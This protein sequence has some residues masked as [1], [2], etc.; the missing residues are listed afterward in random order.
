MSSLTS[1]STLNFPNREGVCERSV[2]SA[3]SASLRPCEPQPARP[4]VREVSQARVLGWVAMP[5]SRGS[6]R[7]R[8]RASISCIFCAVIAF[9]A[10]EPPGKPQTVA[11][12]LSDKSHG[13][14]KLCDWPLRESPAGTLTP[15]FSSWPTAGCGAADTDANTEVTFSPTPLKSQGEQVSNYT[16]SWF[17]HEQRVCFF[18]KQI[19]FV[20][21][22]TRAIVLL[23]AICNSTCKSFKVWVKDYT[24][25][26]HTKPRRRRLKVE[27]LRTLCLGWCK[28]GHLL[29]TEEDSRQYMCQSDG[30]AYFLLL[31][32]FNWRIVAL[33][34]SG[35]FCHTM[36]G[37][38]GKC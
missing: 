17:W 12:A 30:N 35:G 9:F 21:Q 1:F 23:K 22:T 2:S 28:T 34:C 18:L 15:T 10:T 24:L 4:P 25:L 8:D 20:L 7:R 38:S 31:F 37:I 29:Q 33:W 36:M 6:A 16:I 13:A 5:F 11:D 3:V 26:S 19:I 27:R 14:D 32:I